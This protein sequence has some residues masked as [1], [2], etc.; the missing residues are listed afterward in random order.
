MLQCTIKVSDGYAVSQIESSENIEKETTSS[1]C[2][3]AS[4]TSNISQFD[5]LGD[6]E[7]IKPLPLTLLVNIAGYVL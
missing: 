6:G 4:F 2:S 7:K 3:T 5:W 1:G